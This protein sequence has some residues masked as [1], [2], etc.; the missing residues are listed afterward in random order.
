MSP[1][2]PSR[3]GLG[4]FLHQAACAL[5]ATPHKLLPLSSP[6][7]MLPCLEKA[8]KTL[9]WTHA[10]TFRGQAAVRLLPHDLPPDQP[11]VSIRWGGSMKAT[12]IGYELDG[13]N[14]MFF[15]AQRAYEYNNT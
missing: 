1:P 7:I 5:S 10:R 6:A 14:K 13:S 2:H 8:E 15:D 11:L 12:G 9:P 4:T 3:P